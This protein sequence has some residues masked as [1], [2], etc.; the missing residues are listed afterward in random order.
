[1][2]W[3]GT[4]QHLTERTPYIRSLASVRIEPIRKTGLS[5]W[6]SVVF[7]VAMNKVKLEQETALDDRGQF[8][9]RV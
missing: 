4:S 7:R 2:I 3:T 1:M 9:Q 5:D 6:P 8:R